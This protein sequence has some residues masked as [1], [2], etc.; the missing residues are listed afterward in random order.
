[1]A[2]ATV[3]TINED[4]EVV[5]QF[6]C[7]WNLAIGQ[8]WNKRNM[9]GRYYIGKKGEAIPY[10]VKNRLLKNVLHQNQD[11]EQEQKSD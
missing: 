9:K 1:M 4:N 5:D 6:D 3:Y 10:Q 8:Y 11:H 2:T 7:D